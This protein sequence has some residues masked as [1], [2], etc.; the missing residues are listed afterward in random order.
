MLSIF[1]GVCWS[2]VC[3]LWRSIYLDLLAP[4]FWLDSLFVC[5][6]IE[7]HELLIYFGDYSLVSVFICNCFLPFWGLSFHILYGFLFCA[8]SS[9]FNQVPFVYFC[10]YFHYSRRWVKKILLRFILKTVLSMVFSESFIVSG[11]TFRSL[12][13]F[14]FIF[15]Y[16]VRE[17][18]NFLLLHVAIQLSQHHILKKLSFLH[19][20]LWPLL[21]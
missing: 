18:S 14:E 19:C 21:S 3:L 2:S 11:L 6:D 8:K 16:Y 5:F 4:I 9:K 10:F 20:I 7:L 15:I 17:Y 12:I 1:L 13:H